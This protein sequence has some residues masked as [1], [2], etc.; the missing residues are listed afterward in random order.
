[1][2]EK[3]QEKEAGTATLHRKE[4]ERVATTGVELAGRERPIQGSMEGKNP[5]E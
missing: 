3:Q 5:S 1:M 4:K 2:V